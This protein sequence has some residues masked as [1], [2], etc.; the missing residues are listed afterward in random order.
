MPIAVPA[1]DARS[2]TDG[3]SIS[4]NSSVSAWTNPIRFRSDIKPL[5]AVGGSVCSRS[6]L[7]RFSDRDLPVLH[8]ETDSSERAYVSER[9]SVDRDDIGICSGRNHAYFALHTQHLRRASRC[10]A[11]R[12][13]RG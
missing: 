6:K 11:N 12:F 3:A 8:H 5:I 1:S 2:I 4:K 7:Y 13:H 9:I 10:R